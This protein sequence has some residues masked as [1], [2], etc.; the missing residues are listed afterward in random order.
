MGGSKKGGEF[1]SF[2]AI[3]EAVIMA[4]RDG[5]IVFA[6]R[7][8]HRLFGYEGVELIGL[9]IDTLIPERSRKRHAQLVEGFF[10]DPCARP[11]GTKRELRGLR[12]DGKEFPVEIAIGPAESGTY[13]V[14]VVRDLTSIV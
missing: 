13:T 14:A 6:N 3:P 12:R 4:G 2:E 7:H 8:A 1:S 10:A 5:S 11:M 9:S